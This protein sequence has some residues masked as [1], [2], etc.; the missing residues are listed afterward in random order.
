MNCR[1]RVKLHSSSLSGGGDGA[2]VDG[3]PF[4]EPWAAVPM[5]G[6]LVGAEGLGVGAVT[7]SNTCTSKASTQH[8]C[9]VYGEEAQHSTLALF[10][11]FSWVRSRFDLRGQVAGVKGAT[12]LAGVSGGSAPGS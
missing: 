5:F 2:I 9:S 11:L 10:H 8:P 3:V 1:S 12:P 4:S 6:F 7:C